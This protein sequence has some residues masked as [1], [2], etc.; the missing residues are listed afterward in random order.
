MPSFVLALLLLAAV[1]GGVAAT[2]NPAAPPQTATPAPA[3]PLAPPPPAAPT[4]EPAQGGVTGGGPSPK[5]PGDVQILLDRAGFSPGVMDGRWGSNSTKAVSAFQSAHGLPPTGKVDPATWQALLAAGNQVLLLY[6]ITPEDLKG[7]FLPIP[8]DM[9]EKAKLPVL[10]Y[11]TPLEMLAERFHSTEAFLKR[12]NPGARFDVAGQQL[13]MPNVRSVVSPQKGQ[14]PEGTT[15]LVS[16]SAKAL[17]VQ[18]PDGKVL[19]YAPVSAG[20]EHDPLPIGDWKVKGIALNPSFN[21]NPALFWDSEAS[22]VK[23]KIPPGPNNPVGLVWIDLTKEHYGIHGSPVPE[24]IGK[25]FSHG[26][27]RLTNWDALTVAGLVK[28]GTPVLFRE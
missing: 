6:T 18:G 13:R 5:A 15:I 20:S 2:Q 8:E 16:K 25:S 28:P 19:F 1:P 12:L 22:A 27:V 4:P 23:A 9:A 7:P 11:S 24:M 10:G 21:Y 14:V 17:T 3:P 26:C